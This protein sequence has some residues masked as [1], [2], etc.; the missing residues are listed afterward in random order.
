M[1]KMT[2]HFLLAMVLAL[3]VGLSGCGV[4]DHGTDAEQPVEEDEGAPDF[5]TPDADTPEEGEP[6]VDLS[7][8]PDSLATIAAED[9]TYD[10][11]YDQ[12]L[13]YVDINFDA[14]ELGH[15]CKLR[16]NN[17]DPTDLIETLREKI[18]IISDTGFDGDGP[19]TM[20]SFDATNHALADHC[21]NL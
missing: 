7:A 5:D 17:D 3:G 20:R 10:E 2:K 16:E 14:A 21:R 1:K 13:M 4:Q 15:L 6:G 8:K 9:L 18:G 19:G 11:I 12:A